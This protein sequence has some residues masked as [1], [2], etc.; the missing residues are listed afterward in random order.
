VQFDARAQPL[1]RDCC[2]PYCRVYAAEAQHSPIIFDR[3]EHAMSN[4]SETTRF[5][6]EVVLPAQ[7]SWGARC[8]GNTSGARALL[9]A[10]LEDAM[11]CIERRRRRRHPRTRQLAAEAETWMRSDSREWLFSFASICDVLGIDADAVRARLLPTV[12]PPAN[13][14]GAARTEVGVLS[15]RSGAIGRSLSQRGST[16]GLI[17]V[18]TAPTPAPRAVRDQK[19]GSGFGVRVQL[20]V[21]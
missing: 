14:A 19:T 18:D 21:A 7:L 1:R 9:L 20:E 11:L 10:V 8:D 16:P 2:V 15:T 17:A 6:P 4:E 12:E 13:G 5:E 3:K